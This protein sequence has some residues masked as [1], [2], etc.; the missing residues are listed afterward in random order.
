MLD[1]NLT[2]IMPLARVRIKHCNGP[3]GQTETLT[4]TISAEGVDQ[5][6]G[7]YVILDAPKAVQGRDRMYY[8]KEGDRCYVPLPHQY[9]FKHKDRIAL[10]TNNDY[11][12]AH[13][14]YV[15]VITTERN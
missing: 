12:H 5:Y 4:G 15:E 6:G 1:K 10:T 14:A 9:S 11:E 8:Y 2:P 3:Y 13:T 7:A